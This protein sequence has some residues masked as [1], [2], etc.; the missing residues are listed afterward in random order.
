[1]WDLSPETLVVS[2][3]SLDRLLLAVCNAVGRH[4]CNTVVA[5]YRIHS[6]FARHTNSHSTLFSHNTLFLYFRTVAAYMNMI[7][8][9][10]SGHY[11]DSVE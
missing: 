4:R 6:L 11:I 8:T 5:S 7:L 10:L 3:G 9:A 1:M 2:S